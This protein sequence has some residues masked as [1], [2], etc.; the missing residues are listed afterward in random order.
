MIFTAESVK[1]ADVVAGSCFLA[2]S[3]HWL[4]LSLATPSSIVLR[5]MERKSNQKIGHVDRSLR[6]VVAP[7]P[8]RNVLRPRSISNCA[9]TAAA[10]TAGSL[11]STPGRPIGQTRRARAFSERPA[12]PIWLKKRARLVADPMRPT[13]A[14]RCWLSAWLTIARSSGC[15]WVITSTC[16][17]SRAAVSSSVGSCAWTITTLAGARPGNASRRGSI[18]HVMNGKGANARINARPTC[19]AP[20]R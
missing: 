16:E 6:S 7:D 10:I 19:P 12:A 5:T 18:Q 1:V 11:P 15:E 4:D 3:S 9:A 20:N 14:N 13:N 17:R 8:D 2:I